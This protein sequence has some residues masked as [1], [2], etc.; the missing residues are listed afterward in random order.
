MVHASSSIFS[1]ARI[2]AYGRTAHGNVHPVRSF[3][4]SHSR[5][6]DSQGLAITACPSG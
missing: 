2:D 6:R 4:D 3:T 1:V 5:F